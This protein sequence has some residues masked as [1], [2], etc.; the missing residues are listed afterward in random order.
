MSPFRCPSL[1]SILSYLEYDYGVWHPIGGCGE[2]SHAMARVAKRLGV[3]IRLSEEVESLD[4]QDRRVTGVRT[5]SGHYQADAVVMNA[6]FAHAMTHLV[7]D[8][9]RRNW[10][11]EKLERKQFSCS[12]FMLYLG[13]EGT[14]PEMPHHTIQ[15]SSQYRQNLREIEDLKVLPSDPSFYIQN[16]CVTDPSL[17]PEGK[18]TIY[19][20]APVPHK[21]EHID[22]KRDSAAFRQLLLE[23]A[24][25]AG[26]AGLSERICF[27]K[28]VTPDDWEN[29][30]SIFKGA[31]FNLA[32]TLSQ[33]LHFR[34]QNRFEDL[35][36]MYLVGGG[37]H[38]GSG[39]PVIYE[40]ARI[41]SKLLCEDFGVSLPV[42]GC[43]VNAGFDFN[44]QLHS[45][46]A[47][48]AH[49]AGSHC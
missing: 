10:T 11:N 3:E 7:P 39:L 25:A 24:E 34:P 19:L 26:F 44:E 46:A 8:S 32:H 33:M 40:G 23:R 4:F 48:M 15:I 27:E 29:H 28:M 6:D 1:F 14:F 43:G 18:S 35:D 13:V 5:H 42:H 17:A 30:Y 22:W 36:G 9:L 16:A 41:T 45:I 12:T 37:T 31:T 38:P 49:R 21:S 47:K 20:L 2:V